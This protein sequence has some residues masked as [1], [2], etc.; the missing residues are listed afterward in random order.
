MV[1]RLLSVTGVLDTSP[2]LLVLGWSQQRG[3]RRWRHRYSL[4]SIGFVAQVRA[5]WVWGIDMTMRAGWY[6]SPDDPTE[7]KYWDGEDWTAH[8]QSSPDAPGPP[9][10]E[11]EQEPEAEGVSESAPV[12]DDDGWEHGPESRSVLGWII[13]ALVTSAIVIGGFVA[14][15]ALWGSD[16]GPTLGQGAIAGDGSDSIGSDVAETT[17]STLPAFTV[18]TTTRFAIATTT[19]AAPGA[20]ATT[21]TTVATTTTGDATTTTEP[22]AERQVTLLVDVAKLRSGPRLNAT[23]VDTITDLGGST[24]VVLGEPVDG[25]YEVKIGTKQGWMFG[26][27]ILPP[28]SGLTVL[29]TVS[30]AP[31]ALLNSSGQA[32][33]VTSASGSYALATGTSGELWPVILPEGGTGYVSASAMKVRS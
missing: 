16:D 18:P 23:E 26:A 20:E 4:D 33:G 32:L 6:P 30:G 3:Q 11:P 9:D 27:F 1:V 25:W 12:A 29:Q 21:T 7:L 24:I 10:A 8:T 15:T 2:V 13:G 17:S 31:V 28:A 22:S 19:T 14:L 5:I